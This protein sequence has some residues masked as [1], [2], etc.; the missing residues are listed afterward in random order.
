MLVLTQED[1]RFIQALVLSTVKMCF[2]LHL[3]F[4]QQDPSIRT[5]A[6][7]CLER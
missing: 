4:M 7:F 1:V 5:R 3:T 6:I 2:E